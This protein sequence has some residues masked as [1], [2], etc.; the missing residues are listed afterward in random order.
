MFDDLPRHA[1]WS[2]CSARQGFE[3]VFIGS[4]TRRRD[5][6]GHSTAI[7][8]G[9]PWS[10][11]YRISVDRDWRTR[12]A[13]VWIWSGSKVTRHSLTHNGAGRWMVDGEP[14]PHLND[15]L[16]VDLEASAFTN[17]LPAHRFASDIDTLRHA[18]AAYVRVNG[19]VERLEQTY[20]PRAADRAG[21]C[22]DYAAPQFDFACRLEYDRSGLVVEYPG[23]ATRVL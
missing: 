21:Q 11:R 13:R 5:F 23:I 18:P 8:N 9:L 16:D 7:E 1:A 3:V 20:L 14:A 19:A 6:A 22:F 12:S 10:V 15:C 2:H 4:T 17:A